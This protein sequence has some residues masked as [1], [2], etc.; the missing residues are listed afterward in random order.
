MTQDHSLSL[1]QLDLTPNLDLTI[2][3]FGAPRVLWAAIL[4]L[5]R[6]R[7]SALAGLSE[8]DDHLR[9]DMGL[10]PRTTSPPFVPPPSLRGLW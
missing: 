1:P 4:A 7:T 10:P 8:L 2:A 6:P 3:H 9:R 5:L